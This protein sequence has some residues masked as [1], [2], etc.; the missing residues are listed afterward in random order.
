MLSAT[1]GAGGRT[2]DEGSGTAYNVSKFSA[3]PTE[4]TVL[5]STRAEMT[6]PRVTATASTGA[7]TG[8]LL[9]GAIGAGARAAA[10]VLTSDTIA[11][12]R[13][14]EAGAE[15]ATVTEDSPAG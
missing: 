7:A 1:C 3:R 14:G 13:G 15:A 6:L 5:G 12:D 8:G 9:R 10:G 4:T 11:G 2:R